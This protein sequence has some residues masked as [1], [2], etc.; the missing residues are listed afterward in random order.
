MGVAHRVARL[1]RQ[2]PGIAVLGNGTP[3]DLLRLAETVLVRGVDEVHAGVARMVDDAARFLLV[4]R[5]AEH[6]GA[7]TARRDGEAAAAQLA[8]VT[9][10]LLGLPSG[11]A[12]ARF[13]TRTALALRRSLFPT[14]SHGPRARNH[15]ATAPP[16]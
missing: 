2:H 6:H 15:R 12:A 4:G 7:E 8:H 14:C 3:D 5:V 10:R 16:A 1:G 9:G 11:R 13:K